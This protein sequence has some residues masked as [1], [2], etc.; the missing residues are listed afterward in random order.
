MAAIDTNTLIE[1]AKCYLCLGMSLPEALRLAILA[2]ISEG[3]G[4]GGGDG[5]MITFSMGAPSGPADSTTYYLGGDA[6]ASS[7]VW[8]NAANG[9]VYAQNSII[10]PK[11]GTITRFYLK[12]RIH[13]ALASAETVSHFVRINDATDAGQLDL[14][15]DVSSAEG[16]VTTISQPVVAGDT[17]A[18]KMVMPAWVAN[19]GS[20]G[21]Y[22]Y[23]MIT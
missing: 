5:Y 22:G 1:E 15:Y 19:P 9:P 14:S 21:F 8:Q 11:S 3:G 12:V 10:I 2:R 23:I 6:A 20:V 17:F 7:I 4:G 16:L 18:I 13:S